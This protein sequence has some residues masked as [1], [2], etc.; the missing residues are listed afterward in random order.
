M[1]GERGFDVFDTGFARLNP[2]QAG[3]GYRE[4][5][6]MA[7]A[8]HLNMLN[9]RLSLAKADDFESVLRNALALL[10]TGTDWI[11]IQSMN[12]NLDRYK[13]GFVADT[14]NYIATGNRRMYM[15]T[16]RELCGSRN[17]GGVKPILLGS[18]IVNPEIKVPSAWLR[19]HPAE[20]M[21]RWIAHDGGLVD[22][23][24]SLYLM[25]GAPIES[26]GSG[27]DSPIS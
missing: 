23:I 11:V 18:R 26:V 22:L 14:V 27:H 16:W 12:P 21:A 15:A 6:S 4:P 1:S 3:T 5:D 13:V 7:C 20:I 8:H 2:A 9:G 24:E 10:G 17:E 25:F 19:G